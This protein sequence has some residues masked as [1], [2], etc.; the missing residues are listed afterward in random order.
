M[1]NCALCNINAHKFNILPHSVFS[2]NG[3][4]ANRIN[5]DSKPKAL[6]RVFSFGLGMDFWSWVGWLEF[7]RL[8]VGNYF[9]CGFSIHWIEKLFM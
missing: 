5:I 7:N 3:F 2:Y 9:L 1:C 6:G 8:L 4:N